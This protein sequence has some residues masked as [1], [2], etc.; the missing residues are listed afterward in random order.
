MV[1]IAAALVAVWLIRPAKIAPAE[2]LFPEMNAAGQPLIAIYEGRVPCNAPG[3]DKIKVGLGL[4]G[5]DKP[6][7]FRLFLVRVDG[8]ND[9]EAYEG[10]LIL[11]AG[12]PDHP[13]ALVL[14][15]GAAA[16]EPFRSYWQVSA[17]ILIPLNAARR[18]VPGNA[19]WG[20]MLSRAG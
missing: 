2:T 14:D 1:L 10:R 17:D 16:P 15:L 13:G 9:R 11:S 18:P 6:E 19:S 4:Y 12:I 8:G 20:S 3:C 7:S 5:A